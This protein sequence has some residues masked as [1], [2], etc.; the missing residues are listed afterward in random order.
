MKSQMQ[1]CMH[2]YSVLFQWNDKDLF[3]LVIKI[4][5]RRFFD[6]WFKAMYTHEWI[7]A[8]EILNLSLQIF[9]QEFILSIH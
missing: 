8:F 7:K 6:L 9:D 5:C 1:L 2:S 3:I 4:V